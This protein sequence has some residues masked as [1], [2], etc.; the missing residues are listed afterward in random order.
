MP[1][2]SLRGEIELLSLIDF[3]PSR[4]SVSKDCRLLCSVEPHDSLY[5]VD[6]LLADIPALSVGLLGF[7][8]LTFF[9]ILKKV[10]LLVF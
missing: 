9:M 5:Q 3:G 2:L 4:N 6:R 7:A 1:S 8:T 10:K